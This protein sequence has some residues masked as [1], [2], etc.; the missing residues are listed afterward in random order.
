MRDVVTT[1]DFYSCARVAA[2]RN[3]GL[4]GDEDGMQEAACGAWAAKEKFLREGLTETKT[5]LRGY[6][7]GGADL[8][9]RKY[10][11]KLARRTAHEAHVVDETLPDV[12]MPLRFEEVERR[13]VIAAVLDELDA[14]VGGTHAFVARQLLD[15]ETA[16]K[17]FQRE[18]DR[19]GF[20]AETVGATRSAV[21]QMVDTLVE[22]FRRRAQ[23][24]A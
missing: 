20:L 10:V 7:V 8:K 12:S 14:K 18:T 1:T 15:E 5:G 9:L 24:Q 2:R 22:V 17:V 19:L 4:R 21:A 11:A 16:T 6:M 23:Q 13:A 3:A